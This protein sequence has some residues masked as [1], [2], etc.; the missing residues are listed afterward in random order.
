MSTPNLAIT[1]PRGKPRGRPKVDP[2]DSETRQ[3]LIRAGLECLTE[4]GY[5]AV[6]I[7]EILAVA[8]VPK[9]SFYH[10]FSSKADFGLHLV[11]AYGTYLAGLLDR[12]LLN[13]TLKP[14]DRLRAFTQHAEDSMARFDFQRGCLVGN[15]GQEMATLPASFRERLVDVLI[16]WQRRTTVC[17]DA[18]KDCGELND[19]TDTEALATF[20]WTGWEGAVLRAKMERKAE[21]LRQFTQT[22]FQMIETY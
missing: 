9:G 2:N 10:H 16:D 21:P 14:I 8:G 18:A 1:R 12:C 4:K 20:F 22:F 15:L 19:T 13:E 3:R 6:A 5:R 7:D 17:L 11:E